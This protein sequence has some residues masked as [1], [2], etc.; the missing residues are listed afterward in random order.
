VWRTLLVG[1]W[2]S[3]LQNT[4][5]NIYVRMLAALVSNSQRHVFYRNLD[6]QERQYGNSMWICMM[7][8]HERHSVGICYAEYNIDIPLQPGPQVSACEIARGS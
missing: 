4:R 5:T 7:K 2:V 3:M 8:D 6:Q 1:Y